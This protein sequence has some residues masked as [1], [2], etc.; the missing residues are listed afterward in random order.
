MGQAAPQNLLR[1]DTISIWR[2]SWYLLFFVL[3]V[4]LGGAVFGPASAPTHHL[5][6]VHPAHATSGTRTLPE[7]HT[8]V[9][10]LYEAYAH[11]L[12]GVVTARA[13]PEQGSCADLECSSVGP[14]NHAGRFGGGDWPPQGLTMVGTCRIW[15]IKDAIEHVVHAGVEGDFAELGAWRGG[16][17]LYAR[18]IFNALGQD[19]RQVFLFDAWDALQQYI[20]A[21]SYMAAPVARVEASFTSFGLLEGSHFVQGRFK[22]TL[23]AWRKQNLGRKLAILRVDGNLYSSHQVRH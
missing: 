1:E 23:P 16:A 2:S 21:K 3:G 13:F 9:T 7:L 19:H 22:D 12:E 5:C 14:L 8:N 10:A 20:H 4:A 11:M 18:A 17:S 15:N 6:P